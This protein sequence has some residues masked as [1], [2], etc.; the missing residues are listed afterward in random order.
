MKT[1]AGLVYLDPDGRGVAE[2]FENIEPILLTHEIMEKNGFNLYPEETNVFYLNAG[3]RYDL[4]TVCLYIGE[5]ERPSIYGNDS[6]GEKTYVALHCKYVH[7]LQHLLKL[8]KIEK[9]II[10]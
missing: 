1:S 9:E 4:D 10:L 3:Y 2:K 5:I 6:L 7:E 8:C